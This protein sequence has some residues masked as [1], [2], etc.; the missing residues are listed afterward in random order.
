MGTPAADASAGRPRI[1]S[2]EDSVPQE[3]SRLREQAY[4]VPIEQ[5]TAKACIASDLEEGENASHYAMEMSTTFH[6]R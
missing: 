5:L 1:F 2:Y 3:P 4:S 6:M